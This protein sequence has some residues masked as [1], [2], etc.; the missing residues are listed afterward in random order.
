MKTTQNF[1][2]YELLKGGE[3]VSTEKLVEVLA[4]NKVSLPVYI[5]AFKKFIATKSNKSE[6]IS[7]RE[8]RNVVSY[9]LTNPDE[10]QPQYFT[11]VVAAAPKSENTNGVNR[12]GVVGISSEDPDDEL[13]IVEA[14]AREIADIHSSLGLDH[15]NTTVE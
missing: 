12:K 6:V 10:L 5:H 11:K 2:L 8:G 3:A 4:I 15:I 14:S 13:G 7:I 1:K 9:Q